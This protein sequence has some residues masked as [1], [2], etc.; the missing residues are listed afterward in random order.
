MPISVFV[1]GSIIYFLC[2]HIGLYRFFQNAGIEGWKALVPFLSTYLAVK[3]IKKPIWWI[4]VYYI[5]F[6]GFIVWMGIIVELLKLHG[7]FLF[8]EQALGIV[9]GGIYLPYVAYK[10]QA[11]FIGHEKVAKFKKSRKRE[12]LDA[13]S[14]A[15]IAAS[16]IRMFYIE[17]FTIPTSSMEKSLM[18]GDF[19]FVSKTSYGAR[20]PKTPVAVPFTHHSFPPWFP[21]FGG[22]QSYSEIIDFEYYR[23][24]GFGDVERY[25]AVVFNFPEGDTVCLNRQDASYYQLCRDY[26]RKTVWDNQLTNANGVPFFGDITVRPLD[27]KEN[28]IK[29][30]VGLP[31]DKI[32]IKDGVLH[33][34]DEQAY[35]PGGIQYNYA[36]VTDGTVLNDR[37]F[38]QFGITDRWNPM[39]AAQADLGYIKPGEVAFEAPLTAEQIKQIRSQAYIRDIRPIIRPAGFN[40][41][42]V[43]NQNSPIFPNHPNYQWTQDNFGPITLPKA[44]TTVQLTPG[45]LPLYRR[46]IGTYEGNNVSVVDDKVYING[47]VV[48]EYTFKQ[49]YYWMMGDNRHNSQDSRY[50]G[51]VPEDH[52]VGKAVFIWLSLDYTQR[53]LW[54]KPRWSR[55]FSFVKNNGK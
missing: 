9:F 8:W 27:K 22:K 51:F 12:W 28:Y 21:A 41:K 30:C 47:D 48:T 6:V 45:N 43:Y 26:G 3:L 46:A 53:K 5:P 14:F 36:I 40:F 17:A 18:V 1:I 38:S 55:M 20:F 35:I 24:P 33:V 10:E 37:F 34:N 52:I 16:I 7:K 29:R 15:V 50:W 19:L 49:N 42:A 39:G 11:A 13:I 25:D 23:L 54:D 32:E 44:G 2:A 4:A 31:G